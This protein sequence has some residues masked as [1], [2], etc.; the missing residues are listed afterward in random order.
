MASRSKQARENLKES[1]SLTWLR[2]PERKAENSNR[3]WG[4]EEECDGPAADEKE[5]ASLN[6][7]RTGMR[8]SATRGL[9]LVRQDE[10]EIS[11]THSIFYDFFLFG[12][13][14]I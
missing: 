1:S 8:L 5:A 3:M 7:H 13:K 2:K 12:G 10:G 14:D 4:K 11:P 9:G 6:S